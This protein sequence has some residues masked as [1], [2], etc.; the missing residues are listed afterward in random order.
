MEKI[1][2][3][4]LH[5]NYF[6]AKLTPAVVNIDPAQ[7]LSLSGKGDP[8]SQKFTEDIQALYSTAYGIKFHYKEEGKDF[9]VSSL[10]GLWSY[11]EKKYANVTMDDAPTK[12]PRSDWDY[13]LL[14]MM[15]DFVTDKIV[16]RI[17]ETV[18]T[19]KKISRASEVVMK[20]MNEGKVVQI[21]HVGPFNEEPATLKKLNEFMMAEKMLRNGLH[22]EIYLSDFRKTAPGKLKTILR[23]PI[24]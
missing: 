14:I 16:D 8:S 4:K 20:K 21:L 19:K 11:D 2:L 6:K 15:P 10:E 3:A 23:E 24:R 17:K 7:F 12:I 18:V 9:K 13:T 22:H 1:D 5:K